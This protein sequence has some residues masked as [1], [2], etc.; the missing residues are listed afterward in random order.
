[1]N[2]SNYRKETNSIPIE[3]TINDLH[4]GI[5][6]AE[7]KGA[8]YYQC[9]SGQITFFYELEQKEILQNMLLACEES[10]KKIKEELQKY[11]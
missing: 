11:E 7:N 9:A 1:M 4:I 5:L 2:R 8:K 6:E 10:L 3:G